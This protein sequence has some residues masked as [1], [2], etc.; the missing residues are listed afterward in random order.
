MNICTNFRLSILRIGHQLPEKILLPTV[1]KSLM[2]CCRDQ[3]LWE[4][5]AL[6]LNF[7]RQQLSNDFGG[8]KTAS[9]C[10]KNYF[11]M[12]LPPYFDGLVFIF[13]AFFVDSACC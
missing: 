3:M 11:Y 2:H 10:Y 4:V 12:Y 13:L 7:A 1:L 9:N 6:V 8:F 5:M